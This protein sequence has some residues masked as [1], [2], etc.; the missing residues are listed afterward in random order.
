MLN[1]IKKQNEVKCV[2]CEIRM[3]RAAEK[4]QKKRENNIFMMH[5]R[6]INTYTI[7]NYL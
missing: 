4:R 2:W 1:L 5:Q 3:K 6:F 7:L